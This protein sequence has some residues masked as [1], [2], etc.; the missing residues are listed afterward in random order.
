MAMKV[1]KNQPA[2]INQGLI[3]IK[4]LREIAKY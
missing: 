4:N 2:Y 1:I 3:E